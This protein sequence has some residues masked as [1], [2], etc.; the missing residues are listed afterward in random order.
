MTLTS[1]DLIDDFLSQKRLAVV[2][3]SRDPKDFTRKFFGEPWT[4]GFGKDLPVLIGIAAVR[5]KGFCFS[6]WPVS[7]TQRCDP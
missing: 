4:W 6:L 1:R 2:G 7:A 5:K 3:V